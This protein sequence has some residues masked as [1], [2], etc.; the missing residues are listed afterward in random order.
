MDKYRAH[1]SGHVLLVTYHVHGNVLVNIIP[2]F[3]MRVVPV[4]PL[5]SNSLSFVVWHEKASHPRHMFSERGKEIFGQPRLPLLDMCLAPRGQQF[6]P[7]RTLKATGKEIIAPLRLEQL[8]RV[9]SQPH[10]GSSQVLAAENDVQQDSYY[11]TACHLRH[12][13]ETLRK[14][15]F[16]CTL[17]T[18]L[19]TSQCVHRP[20]LCFQ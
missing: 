8:L 16:P 1:V 19:L 12:T 7:F 3:S 5:R 15:T 13:K 10:C 18:S 9:S 2:I 14:G 4:A 6:S 11:H 17:D 20:F